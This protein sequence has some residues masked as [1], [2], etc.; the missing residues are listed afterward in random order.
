M[1]NKMT[2][3]LTYWIYGDIHMYVQA[4]RVEVEAE[5][6]LVYKDNV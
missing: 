6:I 1:P 2:D 5:D 4:K 3:W